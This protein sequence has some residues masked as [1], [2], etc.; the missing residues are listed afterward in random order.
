MTRPNVA[1]LLCL[2]IAVAILAFLLHGCSAHSEGGAYAESIP[3]PSG[4]RCFVVR[5]GGGVAIGGNCL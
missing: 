1:S 4:V 5:N 3:G 2:V